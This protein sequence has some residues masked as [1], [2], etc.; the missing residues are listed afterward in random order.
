MPDDF[1]L[2][3]NAVAVEGQSRLD[4]IIISAEWMPREWQENALLMLPDMHHFMD[5][6]ALAAE[7]LSAEIVA[8]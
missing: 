3:L 2:L 8:V 1:G 7:I 5:K 6:K 4:R